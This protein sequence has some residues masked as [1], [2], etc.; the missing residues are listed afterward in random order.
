L[1]ILLKALIPVVLASTLLAGGLYL[2][3]TVDRIMSDAWATTSVHI[4]TAMV[5]MDS[6]KHETSRILAEVRK[7]QTAAGEFAED[8]DAAIEPLKQSL[9]G[10][11]NSMKAIA[12]TLEAVFNQIIAALNKAPFVN[13]QSVRLRHV[14]NI[15]AFLPKLAAFNLDIKPDFSGIEELTMTAHQVVTDFE[16]TLIQLRSL[17]TVWWRIFKV[18]FY[19]VLVWVAISSIG[20]L[21]RLSDRLRRGIRLLKGERVENG[22]R[23]L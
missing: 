14:F 2:Y 23:Y 4:N 17:F 5:Q 19:L 20:Y 1:L 9:Y 3:L 11:Q 16:R 8:V 7:I 15:P 22:M 18:C 12:A 13:L 6:I 10:I 21:A